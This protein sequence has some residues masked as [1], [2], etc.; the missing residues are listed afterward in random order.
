VLRRRARAGMDRVL[1]GIDALAAADGDQT[2]QAFRKEVDAPGLVAAA[3]A[4][5]AFNRL[6]E[7]GRL[8]AMLARYGRLRQFLP[9]SWRCRSGPPPA[10]C[11]PTLSPRFRTGG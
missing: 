6:E 3:A 1:G 9:A 4:C 10:V 7:R 8:D 5:R 11:P 2:V